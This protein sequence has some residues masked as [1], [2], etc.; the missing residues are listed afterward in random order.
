VA[1]RSRTAVLTPPQEPSGDTAAGGVD[2][3][4]V[5]GDG[6]GDRAAAP[7]RVLVADSS[8]STRSGVRLALVAAECFVCEAADAQAA[9]EVALRERPEVCLLDTALPGGGIAAAAAISA[10][11]PDTSVVMF[12]PL[13]T[14]AD[15][16]AALEAGACGYLTRDVDPDRL[17]I[18]L[19]RVRAGEAAL[20]RTLV[21]DLIQ[22]FRRRRRPL[23]RGLTNRELEVLELVCQ[24]LRTGEIA[25]RLFVARVTVRTHIASILRKLGVPDR[26]AAIRLLDQR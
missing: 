21:A 14:G 23:L 6:P 15:L 7:I 5:S 24:G 13:P 11:L 1:L 2:L 4:S 26:E 19:R 25:D 10:Q 18:A 9:V 17:A 12:G 20:S 8:A 3:F 16:F 22:E